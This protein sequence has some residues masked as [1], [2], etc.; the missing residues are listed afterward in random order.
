MKGSRQNS[1]YAVAGHLLLTV[2]P[3]DQSIN[4]GSLRP[5]LSARSSS[6]PLLPRDK[7]MLSILLI[8][9]CA[10]FTFLIC[11]A[12]RLSANWSLGVFP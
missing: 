4:A 2:E 8:L 10:L 12:F 11:P 5:I 9:S 1:G 3:N 6:S 7:T